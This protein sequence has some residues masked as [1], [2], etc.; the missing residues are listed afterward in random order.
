LPE[1]DF[2]IRQNFDKATKIRQSEAFLSFVIDEIKV[3]F[4][5]DSLSIAME[6]PQVILEN[7]VLLRLDTIDNIASNKLTTLVSRTEPKDFIDFYFIAQK[8]PDL[9]REKVFQD[10]NKKDA[11]FDDMPTASFQIEEGFEVVKNKSIAFPNLLIDIDEQ[12]FIEFY[13]ELIAWLY[14]KGEKQIKGT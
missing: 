11:I 6:R 13:K 14:A 7:N 3:D 10:A 4:V 5:K 1:I 8:Y 12:R 9:D 2:W